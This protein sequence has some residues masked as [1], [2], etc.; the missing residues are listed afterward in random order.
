MLLD[1]LPDKE[2]ESVIHTS[3]QTSTMQQ[4]LVNI[5]GN[6]NTKSKLKEL[7]LIFEEDLI[8][9]EEY[10]SKKKELLSEM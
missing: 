10:N 5:S 8:S 3:Q 6:A 2:Y 7:K 9:E 1:L 4:P